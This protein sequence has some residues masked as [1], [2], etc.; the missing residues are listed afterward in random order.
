ME[1][2]VRFDPRSFDIQD[3]EDSNGVL[4]ATSN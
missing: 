4:E 1:T 2:Q 3:S